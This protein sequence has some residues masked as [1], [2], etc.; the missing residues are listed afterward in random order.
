MKIAVL[1]RK[2]NSDLANEYYIK[3]IER[4]L[5]EVVLIKDSYDIKEVES[6]LKGVNGILLIVDGA[7]V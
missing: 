1:I 2:E 6:F 7:E 5:G 4:F 3:G